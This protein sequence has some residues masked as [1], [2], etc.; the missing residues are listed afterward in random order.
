MSLIQWYTVSLNPHINPPHSATP[1]QQGHPRT[2]WSTTVAS[3]I[4]DKAPSLPREGAQHM[5][6]KI[7]QAPQQQTTTSWRPQTPGLLGKS[8]WCRLFVLFFHHCRHSFCYLLVCGV[9]GLSSSFF[10][11]CLTFFFFIVVILLLPVWH[12]CNCHHHSF[13]IPVWLFF[14]FC[15]LSSFF[16]L[17]VWPFFCCHCHHSFCYLLVLFLHHCHSFC[18]LLALFYFH[19]SFCFYS[20]RLDLGLVWFGLCKQW[21]IA[22][23]ILEDK[24]HKIWVLFFNARSRKKKVVVLRQQKGEM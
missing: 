16:L 6:R 20:Y 17:P 5:A 7:N 12:F 2:P 21:Y 1:V 3:A 13:F 14:L 11:T 23:W 9:G 15:L 22:W 18:Y 24:S 10:V 4:S 19:C 8:T